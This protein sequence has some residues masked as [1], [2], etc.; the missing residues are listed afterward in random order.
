MLRVGFELN[1]HKPNGKYA[2]YCE[3]P[4]NIH[5][6]NGSRCFVLFENNFSIE[7]TKPKRNCRFVMFFS[8]KIF[9][10]IKY[11]ISY[12]EDDFKFSTLNSEDLY[13]FKLEFFSKYFS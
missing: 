12:L 3:Y 10:N 9:S 11:V 5:A 2:V 7:V 1:V 4:G 13:L 8:N 6:E